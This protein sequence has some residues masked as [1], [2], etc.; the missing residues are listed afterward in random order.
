MW[1]DDIYWLPHVLHGKKLEADFLFGE[2]DK[3]LDY[4][5]KIVDEV[6]TTSWV[7]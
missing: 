6:D 5:V 2:G 7:W 3:I 1:P 4:K